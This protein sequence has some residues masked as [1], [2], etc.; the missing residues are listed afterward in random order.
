[1]MITAA[2]IKNRIG[3]QK[4]NEKYHGTMVMVFSSFSSYFLYSIPWLFLI[5]S[6]NVKISIVCL[7][8]QTAMNKIK[9]G[10]WRVVNQYM[11][12]DETHFFAIANNNKADRKQNYL[13]NCQYK[14]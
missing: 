12:M 14:K 4:R 6:F 9:W 1:M 5:F 13:E 2:A 11:D 10:W 8:F 3:R 7:P